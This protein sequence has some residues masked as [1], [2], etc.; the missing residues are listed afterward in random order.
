MLIDRN[1][2][3]LIQTLSNQQSILVLGPRGTGKTSFLNQLIRT[4]KNYYVTD[5]LD[6]DLY[7]NYLK[8]P[9][10]LYSEV[11]ALL[12]QK[13]ATKKDPLYLMIDEIQLLPQLLNEVHRCIEE[14]KSHIVFILTG[15]SARKLKRE[16]ANLLAGRA[17]SFDF[18]PLNFSEINIRDNFNQVMLYGSIP[19]SLTNQDIQSR[20]KYLKTYVHTYLKEE[21]QQESKVRSL[22]G[23][24]H[25]LELAA[26]TNGEP[27]NY[28]KISR[29][30]NVSSTTVKEYFQILSDTLIAYEIPAWSYS[31][32]ESLQQAAKYYLFDNGVINALSGELGSEIKP[33]SF[34]FGRLFE[35]LVVTE[36]IRQHR[37]KEY[38]SKIY[39]YRSLKGHEVDLILQKNPFS[40]AVVIEIKSAEHPYPGKLKSLKHFQKLY[41]ESECLVLC[42]CNQA[43]SEDNIDFYPYEEGIQIA[44][45]K[46]EG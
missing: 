44:L 26:S 29:F 22:D 1:Y 2:P 33:S 8:K 30:A 39:H 34:K 3:I 16:N 7:N 40:K 10:L 4:F 46:A 35:N 19:M 45:K 32:K 14:F 43:Y 17:F 37:I 24:A 38:N 11:K 9:A 13:K 41:P 6:G 25:F 20:T 31:L 27:V 18:Y 23:F 36:L 42:R 21:I 15:S 12:K 28:S 5:L